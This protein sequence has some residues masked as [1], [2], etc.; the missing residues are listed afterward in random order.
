MGRDKLEDVSL[1]VGAVCWGCEGGG[2]GGLCN[3]N[4][5]SKQSILKEHLR[6][7]NFTALVLSNSLGKVPGSVIDWSDSAC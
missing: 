4:P 1:C 5:E 6:N 7:E 2:R 3:C